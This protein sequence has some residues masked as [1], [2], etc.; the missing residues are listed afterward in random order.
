[1][2]IQTN[3]LEQ[4]H[5]LQEKVQ[6][7]EMQVIRSSSIDSLINGA[8]GAKIRDALKVQKNKSTLNKFISGCD[9]L[10]DEHDMVIDLLGN[11]LFMGVSNDGQLEIKLVD[12]GIFK[13]KWKKDDQNIQVSLDTMKKLKNLTK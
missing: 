7:S 11:N 8:D 13:L 5:I 12:Y 3:N 6:V 4:V 1:M 10:L 9:K 2:L